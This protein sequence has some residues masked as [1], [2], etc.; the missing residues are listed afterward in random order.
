M[1]NRVRVADALTAL[2]RHP[3]ALPLYQ[4]GAGPRPDFRTGEKLAR[5]LFF[6]DQPKEALSVLD[7]LPKVTG[8][9]DVDR[10]SLLRARIL[11]DMGRSEEALELYSEV[12]DRLPGDEARCRYAALLLKVGRRGEAQR[13]LEEVEQRLKY[14][15][16]H[17]RA[18]DGRMY[19][20]AMKE[21]TALRA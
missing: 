8:Q 16:R 9:S 13:V 1:A 20:W 4:R 5:S 12:M 17:T 7:A 11:E 21:L 15:D 19:D 2:G 3:E 6:N 10:T 18:S 14:V